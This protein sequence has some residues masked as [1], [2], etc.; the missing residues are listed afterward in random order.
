MKKKLIAQEILIIHSSTL[1]N[2][3]LDKVKDDNTNQFTL[4]EKLADAC[5]QGLLYEVVPEICTNLYLTEI[6]EAN[7]FLELK[8]GDFEN[9]FEESLSINPYHLFKNKSEN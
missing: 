8:Y 5:W 6:N 7:S 4:R 9:T 3:Q 1:F 2:R